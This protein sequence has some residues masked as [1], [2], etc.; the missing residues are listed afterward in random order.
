[1]TT[2]TAPQQ[3]LRVTGSAGRRFHVGFALAALVAVGV[4]FARSYYLRP[5]FP[6]HPAP[7]EAF[8]YTVHGAAFTAW[9]VLLLAQALL[10][11]NRRVHLHRVL[12]GVGAG[13][14][15]VMIGAGV[16]GALLAAGR[17]TGFVGIPVPGWAFLVV[18]LFGMVFFAAFVGA[19]IAMRGRPEVHR[20]L[21]LLATATLL[22]AAV[23]RWPGVSELG[24]PL[25]YFA[26][27]DLFVVAMAVHDR[28]RRG[29]LHPVTLWGGLA[30][31]LS[32][33]AQLALSTTEAWHQFASA[34]IA[35]VY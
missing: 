13:L 8:F 31:I 20:R 1:M 12:G 6:T 3:A 26:L 33:P 4:G 7:A 24:N 21:M 14:A 28:R 29:R 10:V 22:T 18:P 11:A 23:A 16:Y 19:A 35:L 15:V 30:L 9:F 32:Q 25:V 2:L 34:A 5:L 17:P 27:G